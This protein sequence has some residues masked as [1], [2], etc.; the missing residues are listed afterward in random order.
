MSV[1]YCRQQL[2]G[3]GYNILLVARGKEELKK[4]AKELRETSRY[5]LMPSVPV[6]KA[7]VLNLKVGR[8]VVK[9]RGSLGVCK[10]ACRL[11]GEV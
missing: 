11:P 5:R 10:G 9:C 4:A 6:T 7:Y 1:D 2:A 8:C 3:R